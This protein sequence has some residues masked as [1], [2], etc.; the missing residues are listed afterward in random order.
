MLIFHCVHS[1]RVRTFEFET[2]PYYNEREEFRTYCGSFC[3]PTES[4]GKQPRMASKFTAFD[5]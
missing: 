4:S 3:S 1:V 2:G 5:C